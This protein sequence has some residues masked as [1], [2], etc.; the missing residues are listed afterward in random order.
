MII[1]SPCYSYSNTS[2]LQCPYA[3][4]RLLSCSWCLLPEC[5]RLYPHSSWY[6]QA[7]NAGGGISTVLI[8]NSMTQGP[9]IDFPSIIGTSHT[10]FNVPCSSLFVELI[11]HLQSMSRSNSP[12][13]TLSWSCYVTL[14]P[15]E[16]SNGFVSRLT[17]T[18]GMIGIVI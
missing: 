2:V 10:S 5:C 9:A 15:S 6:S 8:N 1:Y 3:Q 17:I 12:E 14:R 18:E 4:L 16:P 13:S 11:P 7:L